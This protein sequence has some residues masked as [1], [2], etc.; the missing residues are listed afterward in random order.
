[1]DLAEVEDVLV[2]IREDRTRMATGNVAD[3]RIAYFELLA[4]S[5]RIEALLAQLIARS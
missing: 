4:S 2:K 1:M 3:W 5:L